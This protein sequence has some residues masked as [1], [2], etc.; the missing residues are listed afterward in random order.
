[1]QLL[2]PYIY[3]SQFLFL[4][5]DEHLADEYRKTIL[6]DVSCIYIPEINSYIRKENWDSN[7][8]S[9]DI[10]RILWIENKIDD[11]IYKEIIN[12]TAAHKCTYVRLN[13][14]HTF[15]KYAQKN[16]LKLLST[17]VSQHLDLRNVNVD[18]DKSFS[19]HL[20]LD[21]MDLRNEIINQVLD[22]SKDSFN[23][24]RFK[25]DPFFTNSQIMEIYRDWI[26]NEV[27]SKSCSLYYLMENEE[28]AAFFLYKSNISPINSVKI[29]FVSLIASTNKFKKKKYASNLLN[30]VLS[31]MRLDTCFVIA[32][33]EIQNNSALSFFSKNNF[34]I[35]SYLNE[36]HIWN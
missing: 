12:N 6:S 3:D 8:F 36:Y 5:M 15:C 26:I 28:V 32:N 30:Y 16:D 10:A 31:K 17:K 33:T 29:G 21:T 13:K 14:E 34:L 27:K 23:Y 19:Y 18:Y 9:I 2:D 24:N 4:K 35:T 20:Y 25:S 22:L 1:M 7:K 11:N